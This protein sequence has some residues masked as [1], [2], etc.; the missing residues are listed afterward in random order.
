[1]IT[2]ES[3]YKLR[4]EKIENGIRICEDA[5][6][7]AEKY[8][9]LKENKDWQAFLGDLK[10]LGDLHDKEIRMGEQ[11][12]LDAPNTG[13]L[14]LEMDKQVYVSSRQDWIDFIVR[15]QIQK[16]ENVKWIKEQDHILKFAD[17]CREK[18]PTLQKELEA[19]RVP[20]EANGKS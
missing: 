7:K 14:K 2:E 6:A 16:E 4:I 3:K 9:R 17:M 12:L 20:V 5:I 1:M 11:M 10:V 18:L 19:L 13:Y 8:E 15:H